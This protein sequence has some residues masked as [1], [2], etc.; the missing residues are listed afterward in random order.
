MNNWFDQGRTGIDSEFVKHITPVFNNS[1]KLEFDL[2]PEN[3][4]LNFNSTQ[5]SCYIDISEDFVPQNFLGSK[6]FEY[7]ELQINHTIVNM[8]SS[9][10]D[11]FLTDFFIQKINVPSRT[12]HNNGC[13]NGIF[14]DKNIGAHALSLDIEEIKKRRSISEHRSQEK[15]YRYHLVLNLNLSLRDSLKPLPKECQIKLTFFRANANKALLCT[16]LDPSSHQPTV[17]YP[18][19]TIELINPVLN[20]MYFKSEFFDKQLMPHMID[21]VNWP[22]LD[23]SFGFK[24]RKISLVTRQVKP[25]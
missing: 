4:F 17:N 8:K 10:S 13:F 22:F 25:D 9:D 16:T 1:E 5:L 18:T 3:S 19:T 11:Y 14:S 6:L 20:A 24:F 23:Y 2:P 15:T 12:L 21:H 7:L